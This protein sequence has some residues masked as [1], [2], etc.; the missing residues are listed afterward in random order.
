MRFLAALVLTL[1]TGLAAQQPAA[2]AAASPQT[3]AR[4]QTSPSDQATALPPA[5]TVVIPTVTKREAAEAKRQFE[6]AVKLRK[7]GDLSA[8]FD[9]FSSASELDPRSLDYITTR[10][11]CRQQLALQALQQGN[12]AVQDGNE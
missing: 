6:A 11:Y 3:P 7:A 8:A 2:P 4:T 9:K 10:E 5:S 1:A 12:K